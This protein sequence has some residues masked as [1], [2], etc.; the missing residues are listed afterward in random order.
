MII[1]DWT[2]LAAIAVVLAFGQLAFSENDEPGGKP[3]EVKSAETKPAQKD[4]AELFAELD[5]NGDGKLTSDE[6]SAGQKRFFEHLL[7]VAGKEKDGELTKE[8]FVKGFKPDDLKVIPPPNFPGP[9]GPGGQFNPGQLF[10]RFDR[11]KDGKLTFD[12]IPEPGRERFKAMFDRLGKKELTKE[13][14]VQAMEQLRGGGFGGGAF[15]RDAEGTF[16]RFDVNQDGKL[17]LDEAPEPVRPVIERW[18]KRAGKEKDGSLSL[19]DVKK[20]VAENQAREGNPPGRPGGA[21]D[22]QALV[23]RKLDTNGDGKLSKEEWQKAGDIFSDLDRN[24]DGVIDPQELFGPPRGADGSAAGNGRPAT[25]P[26]GEA[27]AVKPRETKSPAEASA[28][29]SSKET[30]GL[31]A[32]LS[33]SEKTASAPASSTTARKGRRFMAL[34]GKGQGPGQRLDTNGD[35][36]ISRAEARGRLKEKFDTIDKNSDGFLARDE[37]RAALQ[38]VGAK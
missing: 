34:Q 2:R 36:K 20:I 9:G 7:R 33:A 3:A 31:N 26:A 5:K 28:P 37:I 15:M 8:E 1:R 17:T 14:F 6:I 27:P 19:E 38:Q 35:G 29:A 21:G 32:S 12:E 25:S 10:Q 11:N 13:E 22:V 18:L 4:P 16:K 24:N 23:F 30:T